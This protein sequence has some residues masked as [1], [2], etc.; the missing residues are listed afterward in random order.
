M[1]QKADADIFR[2]RLA[3]LR[4][5]RLG[6]RSWWPQYLF[7]FADLSNVA[8][9]LT[10]GELLSRGSVQ[11]ETPD[12]S[13]SA[14]PDI[15]DQTD[16]RWKDYVRF[17]FRPKTPTLYR[18][19]G[20]RP[21]GRRPLSGAHCPSPVYLLFDFEEVICRAD[22]LFSYGSLARGGVE[23]YASGEQFEQLPFDLVY[24]D[25]RFSKE[26]RDDIIFRRHAEVIV[27][28][29]IGLESLRGV[30]CRSAAEFETLR[31]LLPADIWSHWRNHIGARTDYA[32]F[33][34]E[35]V[36]VDHV[37]LSPTRATF[38]FNP[39]RNLM[40]AG[41]FDLQL[42]VEDSSGKSFVWAQRDAE[43]KTALV[44]DLTVLGQPDAYQVYLTLDQ[45]V[46]YAGRYSRDNNPI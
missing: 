23:V 18:N 35:W 19:E 20:F 10:S 43:I 46:A 41:P 1:M 37:A 8:S 27:P 34:R 14:S 25:S 29:R 16:Q 6:A 39:A 40:D 26:E 21:V 11:A 22:S 24:H 4:R 13:D 33:N 5:A 2:R 7:H 45:H 44:I 31:A 42:E 36:Y 28:D 32:L 17:Y 9:I 15:I 30:M 3:V 12:F 38:H